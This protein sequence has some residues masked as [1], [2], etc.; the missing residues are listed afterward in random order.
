MHLRTDTCTHSCHLHSIP[1][2]PPPSPLSTHDA[3]AQD[4][5]SLGGRNAAHDAMRV[6]HEMCGAPSNAIATGACAAV[7]NF[8]GLLPMVE[9]SL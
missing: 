2:P 1:L 7:L 4:V 8:N 9:V 3:R 5:S 6:I